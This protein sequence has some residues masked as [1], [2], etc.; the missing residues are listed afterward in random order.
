MLALDLENGSV[1][2]VVDKVWKDIVFYS[3]ITLKSAVPNLSWPQCSRSVEEGKEGLMCRIFPR[4]FNWCG[5][6]YDQK[7]YSSL[8]SRFRIS[9]SFD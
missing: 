8:S 5:S 4:W 1:D 2:A 7:L 6:L 3:I 9:R